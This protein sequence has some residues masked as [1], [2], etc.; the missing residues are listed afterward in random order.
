MRF[1][2]SPCRLN[3]LDQALLILLGAFLSLL[4][5]DGEV[6]VE[7]LRIPIVVGFHDLAIPVVLDQVL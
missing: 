6:G 5:L 3:L 2:V 7:L 1:S 4:A